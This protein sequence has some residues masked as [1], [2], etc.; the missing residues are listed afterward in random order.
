M[1][2]EPLSVNISSSTLEMLEAVMESLEIDNRSKFVE[3]AIRD[4]IMMELGRNPLVWRRLLQ[5]M[6]DLSK[7]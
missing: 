6:A 1:T 7:G 3:K 2:K 5:E 4:R